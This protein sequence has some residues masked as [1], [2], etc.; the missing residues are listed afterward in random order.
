MSAH[1]SRIHY[2]LSE[3]ERD[4]KILEKAGV[5]TAA[6]LDAANDALVD[7]RLKHL[8]VMARRHEIAA[9]VAILREMWG[10]R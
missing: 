5:A 3:I 2:K 9:D 8:A 4:M 6:A 10:V 1:N 7:A